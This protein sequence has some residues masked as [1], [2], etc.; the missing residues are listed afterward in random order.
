MDLITRPAEEGD[1]PA[2]AAIY[3]QGIEDRQATFET[4]LRRPE[5]LRAWFNGLPFVVGE[6]GGRVIGFARTAPY[7]D[8][9]VYS[10]VGEF[11]IYVARPAR[12]RGAGRR[13]L[14]AL[15]EEAERRGL[16]KLTGRIF[17]TNEASLRV[18]RDCGF[19]EVGVQLR[20]GRV[21][22]EWKDCVLVERLLGEAAQD[23]SQAASSSS[24]VGST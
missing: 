22:G 5:E 3:N 11:A 8:R 18:A 1:L 16:Y 2:V 9:C 17:T 19:R 6:S 24:A 15:C 12:G 4:R 10:G 7:S 14:A 21:E 13:I 23:S 20:H